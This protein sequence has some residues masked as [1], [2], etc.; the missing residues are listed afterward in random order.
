MDK[1]LLSY[2]TGTDCCKVCGK[3]GQTS[4][5]DSRIDYDNN[6][7]MRRHKCICGA[8]WNTYEIREDDLIDKEFQFSTEA[9]KRMAGA[10]ERQEQ[11]QLFATINRM[12]Q[13]IEQL[14]RENKQLQK[15]VNDLY[16]KK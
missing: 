6:L 12:A 1:R 11:Q 8:R 5:I 14:S 3:I 4:V 13:N 16:A 7:R 10:R 15:L 2:M 9:E